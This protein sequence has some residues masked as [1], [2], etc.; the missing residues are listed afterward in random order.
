MWTAFAR[1]IL[2][3]VLSVALAAGLVLHTARAG[4]MGMKASAA[5]STNMPM[6]GK[7]DRCG[8]DKDSTP[9]LCSAYCTVVFFAM[10]TVTLY[11]V[12]ISSLARPT[13]L[14]SVGHSEPPDPYPPRPPRPAS[15]S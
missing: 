8:D 4:D 15:L 9:A 6:P 14:T 7:C 1:P 5:M 3:I 12:P 11:A 10:P 2:A 13:D